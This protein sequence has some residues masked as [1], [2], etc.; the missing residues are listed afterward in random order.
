V[1]PGREL[2]AFHRHLLPPPSGKSLEAAG[3]SQTLVKPNQFTR[4]RITECSNISK[5]SYPGLMK[6]NTS[7]FGRGIPTFWRICCLHIYGRWL[8]MYVSKSASLY[9][10]LELVLSPYYEGR[11]LITRDI[12]TCKRQRNRNDETM[13]RKFTYIYTRIIFS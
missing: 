12:R 1:Y 11:C 10:G 6:C 4:R 8:F 7:Y 5:F 3:F 2:L 9:T 13:R